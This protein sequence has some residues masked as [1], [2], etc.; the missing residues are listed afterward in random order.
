M[1]QTYH[2]CGKEAIYLFIASTSALHKNHS[3]YLATSFSTK[4]QYCSKL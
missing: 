4:D 1:M 2:Q 3:V